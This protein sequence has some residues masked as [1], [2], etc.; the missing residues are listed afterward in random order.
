[1]AIRCLSCLEADTKSRG[2]FQSG[3]DQS[4]K[5]DIAQYTPVEISSQIQYQWE[6]RK[7]SLVL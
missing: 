1:M 7:Q 3:S 6:H 5:G 2:L 4:Q